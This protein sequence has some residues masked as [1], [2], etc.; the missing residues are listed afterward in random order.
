MAARKKING[1]EVEHG[2]LV[3]GA[4]GVTYDRP[5]RWFWNP[6]GLKAWLPADPV[7]MS[8]WMEAGWSTSAPHSPLKRPATQK[9]RDGS[10]YEFATATHD[11]SAAEIAR[12]NRNPGELQTAVAQASP[13]ATYYTKEGSALHNL[14]ADPK[15]MAD[16]LAAGLTLDP[17]AKALGEVVQL[18]VATPR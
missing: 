10:I 8:L 7:Q 4:D 14:P 6:Y 1:D 5:Y 11:P 3:G 12:F 15:S 17:P 2:E 16:Y 13:T 9:M 18:K